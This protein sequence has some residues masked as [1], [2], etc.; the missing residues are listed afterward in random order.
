MSQGTQIVDDMA[1]N[2]TAGEGDCLSNAL[3][4]IR[5]NV[6]VRVSKITTNSLIW[7]LGGDSGCYV[8]TPQKLAIVVS[9]VAGSFIGA[10]ATILI[11][12]LI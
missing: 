12:V 10:V 6:S 2:G 8:R 9:F 5:I 1:A 4:P 7:L 3:I 11:Q